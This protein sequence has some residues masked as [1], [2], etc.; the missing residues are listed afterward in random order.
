VVSSGETARNWSRC[1][2]FHTSRQ[3]HN[4]DHY[5]LTYNRRG[6]DIFTGLAHITVAFTMDGDRIRVG[7]F[8][9]TVIDRR[10]SPGVGN[11][12][13]PAICTTSDPRMVSIR[14]LN[15]VDGTTFY[16]WRLR[17]SRHSTRTGSDPRSTP[18]HICS[19]TPSSVIAN[20]EHRTSVGLSSGI[21][22]I[23]G[24]NHSKR[25]LKHRSASLGEQLD[26]QTTP[27][28]TL[29]HQL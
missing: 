3:A 5:L 4:N 11:D 27:S 17:H 25:S 20:G 24:H 19:T 8:K 21:G 26:K 1:L 29:E 7:I 12:R 13:S 18:W 9:R 10:P 6:M 28:Q 22:R 16:R 14:R 23:I 2:P 15:D